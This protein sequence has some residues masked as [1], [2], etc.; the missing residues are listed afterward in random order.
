MHRVVTPSLQY[1]IEKSLQIFSYEDICTGIDNYTQVYKSKVTYWEHK[2]TLED[3][4]K[5]S[6]GMGK[7]L[8]MT[9]KDFIDKNK[10]Q[11]AA[12]KEVMLE[13]KKVQETD[14]QREQRLKEAEA[15][16]YEQELRQYFAKLKREV[17]EMI[18]K[19]AEESIKEKESMK[20]THSYLW[21]MLRKQAIKKA[22][23]EYRG[24]KYIS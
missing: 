8:Y 9:E 3:F 14:S 6:G 1:Q 21:E 17:Q 23:E 18:V 22:T 13:E 4:L 16:K 15:A 19:T 24:S 11:T 20:A 12:A 5:R 10:I 7:F 2:W